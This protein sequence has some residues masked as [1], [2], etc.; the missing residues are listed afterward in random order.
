MGGRGLPEGKKRRKL[1][2][3]LHASLQRTNHLTNGRNQASHK[4][5]ESAQNEKKKERVG[6]KRNRKGKEKKE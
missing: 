4:K 2:R 6:R 5:R 1:K 3:I